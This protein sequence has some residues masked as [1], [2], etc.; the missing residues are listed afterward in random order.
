MAESYSIKT[1]RGKI[2]ITKKVIAKIIVDAVDQFEGRFLFP[3]KTANCLVRF[4]V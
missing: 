1:E 2:L 3:I 4:L